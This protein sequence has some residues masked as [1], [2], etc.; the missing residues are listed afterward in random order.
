MRTAQTYLSPTLLLALSLLFGSVAY[1]QTTSFDIPPDP[2]TIVHIVADP[3]NPSP[4]DTVHLSLTGGSFLDLADSTVTWSVNGR[5]VAKGTGIT[6]FDMVMG[7]LGTESDVSVSVVA[8]DGTESDDSIAIIPTH[9]DLLMDSDSYTPPFYRG[10]AL[11]STGTQLHLQARVYFKHTDGA[12][13]PSSSIIYT[14]SRNGE[15]I[16]SVSGVG[17][18]SV[19]IPA[20]MLY[21]TDTISVKA[22]SMDNTLSGTASIKIA[23]VDPVLTLYENH[24][25]FGI[26]YHQAMSANTFIPDSEM[27]FAAIPYFAQAQSANDAHLQYA[28]QVNSAPVA[29]NDSHVSEIT[30]NAD[31]F[32]GPATI[33]LSITH[34][35]N[36][37]IN[38]S[39]S[40]SVSFKSTRQ[41]TNPFFSN[42]FQ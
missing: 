2:R 35:T 42:G 24:P 9:I 26:I 29:G 19:T 32:K 36:F 39:G 30:I 27:T 16:G 15:V 37:L 22:I 41:G 18:S 7:A 20:P 33:N 31:N 11:P 12:L 23:S 10:R 38:P 1:A 34:T 14:W 3:Q 21:G 40:W 8:P 25:L 6:T 4:G 13:I 17:H 5:S 28:W